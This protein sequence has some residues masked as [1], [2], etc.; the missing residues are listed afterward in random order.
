M[1]WQTALLFLACAFALLSVI[2]V[3]ACTYFRVENY[4]LRAIKRRRKKRRKALQLLGSSTSS[5][6]MC[7]GSSR[8]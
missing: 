8:R 3:W 2:A 6:A 7:T 4:E 5:H 1:P